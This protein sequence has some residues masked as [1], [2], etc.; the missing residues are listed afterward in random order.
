CVFGGFVMKQKREYEI[1]ERLVSS[2]ANVQF[3]SAPNLAA[4]AS[5][6]GVAG[7]TQVAADDGSGK[8]LETYEI[9]LT[10]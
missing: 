9:D 6:A 8:G 7:I 2:F 4:L 3:A 1:Q 10:Q 5:T